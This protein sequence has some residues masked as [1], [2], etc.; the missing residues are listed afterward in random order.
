MSSQAELR[1]R[2]IARI[3]QAIAQQDLSDTEFPKEKQGLMA[4][5]IADAVVGE[6]SSMS[7]G[8]APSGSSISVFNTAAADDSTLPP[9]E[10]Q[11]LWEGRPWLSLVTRYVVTTERIRIITGLFGRAHEDIELVRVQDIDQ[12][13]R[14][15]QRLLGLGTILI[16]TADASMPEAQLRNIRKP[17]VVHELT[18][19]AML[20]QRRATNFAFRQ[21]FGED[22]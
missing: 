11:I 2:V 22:R 18:R 21:E 3:W 17:L 15:W 20:K 6:V 13:Q 7:P 10:E 1:A 9:E 19:R 12:R 8:S 14:F 5:A 16:N 4:E